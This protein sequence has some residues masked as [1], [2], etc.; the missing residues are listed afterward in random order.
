[1]SK[2]KVNLPKKGDLK[3]EENILGLVEA[4][5]KHIS[6][7]WRQEQLIFNEFQRCV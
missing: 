2:K 4:V 1:L 7:G 5:K 6:P 3:E